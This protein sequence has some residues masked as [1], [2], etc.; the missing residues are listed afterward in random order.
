MREVKSRLPVTPV[1]SDPKKLKC[2]RRILYFK[3][4]IGIMTL[5]LI[6]VNSFGNLTVVSEEPKCIDDKFV[7]SSAPIYNYLIL[8]ESFRKY[9]MF[10]TFLTL[11]LSLL[12]CAVIFILKGKNSR[13]VLTLILFFLF[14][15][16][17]S[18]IFIIKDN[19]EIL[20]DSPGFPSFAVSF[21]KSENSYFSGIVGLYVIIIA[22]LVH[23]GFRFTPILTLVS[24]ASYILLSL[25]LRA[26]YFISIFS[27]I[28]SAHYFSIL[29][30]RIHYFV[31][32]YVLRMAGGNKSSDRLDSVQETNRNQGGAEKY[33]SL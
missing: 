25:S 22:E 15:N 17:C 29:T 19:N 31:D 2:K 14:R 4:L 8:N 13:P 7:D 3:I 26:E 10:A 28:V 24:M 30:G 9:W 23:N 27:A 18:S 6:L 11:D 32:F 16:F 5:G 12:L 20:W 1:I 21:G 33:A